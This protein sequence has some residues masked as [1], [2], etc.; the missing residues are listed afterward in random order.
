MK[1]EA[2]NIGRII[3][4]IALVEILKEQGV[5]F[6]LEDYRAKVDLHQIKRRCCDL[7]NR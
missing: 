2:D 1:L 5:K 7:W 3:K 4:L 6:V